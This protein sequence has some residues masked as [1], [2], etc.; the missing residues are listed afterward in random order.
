MPELVIS[1]TSCLILLTKIHELDLL[2]QMYGTVVTTPTIVAEFGAALPEW[3][4]VDSA[5]DIYRQQLL[6]MQ[7]GPGEA[8][9]IALALELRGST[10]I[11]DDYKARK[12][13]SRYVWYTGKGEGT[14][15][16]FGS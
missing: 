6:E 1:D 3:V 9:A 7:L 11:L 4:R 16:D 12:V 10:I 2:R 8:S 5:R 13:A 15:A 14:R